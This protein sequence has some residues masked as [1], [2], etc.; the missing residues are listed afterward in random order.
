MQELNFSSTILEKVE[1]LQQHGWDEAALI[2]YINN[3]NNNTLM[4][5]SSIFLV[6]SK[7]YTEMFEK[8]QLSDIAKVILVID[9]L[10]G[11]LDDSG[12][13]QFASTEYKFCNK[14]P[15]GAPFFNSYSK[16]VQRAFPNGLV[17]AQADKKLTKTALKKKY[18]TETKIHQFRNRLDKCNIEYVE[19]YK[20]RYDLKNDEAAIKMI[21]GKD[22]FYADPQYHNRAHLGV[23]VSADDLNKGVRTLTNKGL[24]KKIRKRGFYRKILSGDYHSEFIIDE[25]GRLLS[26]W[27]E[28]TQASDYFESAIANG[29][30][31]NYG[32]RPRDDPYHTHDKLDGKPPRYFDTDKRN[33]IKRNWISPKDN[34]VYQ[35][36]RRLAEKGLRYKKR[37]LNKS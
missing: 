16:S 17:I 4:D 12:D 20:E 1:K 30:S 2:T 37:K 28:Q 13:L 7:I 27:K 34:W 24:I 35:L 9:H 32:E 21:L 26:Q 11:Y 36:I 10:G 31:F 29:E 25:Q 3:L 15:P 14:M 18:A 23:D 6:G 33:E 19:K 8:S 22:W 5:H